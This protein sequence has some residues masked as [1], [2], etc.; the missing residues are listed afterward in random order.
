MRKHGEALLQSPAA[1]LERRLEAVLL[2]RALPLS[3]D[4]FAELRGVLE[5]W[6]SMTRTPDGHQRREYD[7]SWYPVGVKMLVG[8]AMN[9]RKELLLLQMKYLDRVHNMKHASV[10]KLIE[11]RD[12]AWK[13]HKAALRSTREKMLRIL[14]EFPSSR[15]EVQTSMKSLG[16]YLD[17]ALLSTDVPEEAIPL[18]V[19]NAKRRGIAVIDAV[20]R[21]DQWSR[22][23]SALSVTVRAETD[24]A[25][26]A[27][28]AT[29][30]RVK[31]GGPCT[32]A[33]TL[34]MKTLSDALDREESFPL[35]F[36]SFTAFPHVEIL[37][38]GI[39]VSNS[40]RNTES[41]LA[42]IEEHISAIEVE[43][44]QVERTELI[45]WTGVELIFGP[46]HQTGIG[47]KYVGRFLAD[48]PKTSTAGVPKPEETNQHS[49][50][51]TSSC[52]TLSAPPS[53]T[54]ISA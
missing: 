45:F 7:D 9:S 24:Q 19:L 34:A 32:G 31:L 52:T 8:S 23:A 2:K 12:G 29:L 13:T 15:A 33:D 46:Y 26:A 17:R 14:S 50:S 22:R 40:L 41:F 25:A 44:E 53:P 48:R 28:S 43:L 47:E 35:Y 18:E 54:R 20:E 39:A 3:P 16:E 49:S 11:D 36:P 42:R 37:A 21:F 30:S 5:T 6:S 38:A 51:E 4:G 10:D 1:E 27:A